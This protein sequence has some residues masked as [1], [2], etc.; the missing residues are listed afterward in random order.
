[1]DASENEKAKEEQEEEEE[2]EEEIVLNSKTTRWGEIEGRGGGGSGD[3]GM[4]RRTA[5]HKNSAGFP[6][7]FPRVS[8]HSHG[9]LLPTV[10]VRQSVGCRSRCRSMESHPPTTQKKKY[11]F[12][13][14]FFVPAQETAGGFLFPFRPFFFSSVDFST[15]RL[16]F[17]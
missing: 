1:M 14:E 11:F 15:G 10:P 7:F 6:A 12:V 2:D 8:L 13:N 9:S 3:T 5:R 4:K 16:L 17:I